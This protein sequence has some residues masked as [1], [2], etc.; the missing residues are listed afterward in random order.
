M[1]VRVNAQVKIPCLMA[2]MIA[3]EESINEMDLLGLGAIPPL[4]Y[5]IRVPS[6]LGSFAFR[7]RNVL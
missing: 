3:G 6:T 4:C 2:R 1:A 5:G 7:W